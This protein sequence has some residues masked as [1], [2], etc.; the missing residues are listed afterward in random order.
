MIADTEE[1][2]SLDTEE[3]EEQ[4]A[5]EIQPEEAAG[6]PD[7]DEEEHRLTLRQKIYIGIGLTV[8]FFFFTLL[9]FPKDLFLRAILARTAASVRIDFSS[10]DPGLFGQT[11]QTLSVIL[12]D[13]T[14]IL[15]DSLDSSLHAFD[16]MR[17]SAEGKVQLGKS[18]V[19]T[20][21]LA[22]GWASGDITTNLSGYSEGLTGMRG[23]LK[24]GLRDVNFVRFPPAAANLVPIRPD[25]IKV[26]SLELP[27]SFR[28][29]GLVLQNGLIASNLFIVKINTKG[30]YQ[31]PSLDGMN[32]DGQICLKPDR[33]LE[34]KE[35]DVFGMYVFAGGAAGGELC[36]QVRGTVGRPQFNKL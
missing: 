32:L 7:F 8:S 35:P 1:E 21:G 34:Q 10:A 22:L 4:V 5:A 6:E 11:F 16:L 31:G 19:S 18:D 26:S 24:I 30:S 14:A 33:E 36:F 3:E 13:G 17:G 9:L 2:N 15:V 20:T 27:L 23:D 28:D 25:K 12:P 29:G